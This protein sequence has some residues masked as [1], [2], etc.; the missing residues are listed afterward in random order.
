LEID[1]KRKINQLKANYLMLRRDLTGSLK[2]QFIF[3]VDNVDVC[4][5]FKGAK[6]LPIIEDFYK[7]YAELFPNFP[8]N[9]PILPGNY[10]VKN[11][12]LNSMQQNDDPNK[13]VKENQIKSFG[14]WSEIIPK[15]TPIL[16]NGFYKQTIL[17]STKSD[18]FGF[19]LSWVTQ[20][21]FRMSENEF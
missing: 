6:V 19:I 21:D 5:L 14:I 12:T 13:T 15:L 1:V 20:I 2:W 8:R 17:L 4:A 3:K 16:P 10:S 9:C 7:I 18:Q 11:I